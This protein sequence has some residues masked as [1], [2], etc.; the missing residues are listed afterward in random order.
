V[1]GAHMVHVV[2]PRMMAMANAVQIQAAG[3][4]MLRMSPP[5]D[6]AVRL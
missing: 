3:R 1:P 5:P 2:I 4:S 6:A